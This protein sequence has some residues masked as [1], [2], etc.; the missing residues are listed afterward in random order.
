MFFS[1]KNYDDNFLR[2]LTCLTNQ[3]K[4][5]LRTKN[6]ILTIVTQTVAE[7]DRFAPGIPILKK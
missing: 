1:S 2:A 6:N 4:D 3:D 7:N 5:I